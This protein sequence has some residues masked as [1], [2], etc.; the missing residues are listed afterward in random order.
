VKFAV[1]VFGAALIK[2]LTRRRVRV[3]TRVRFPT[4]ALK[5]SLARSLF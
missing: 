4:T 1:V 5:F 3:E 2:L